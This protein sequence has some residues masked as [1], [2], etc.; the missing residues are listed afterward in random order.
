MNI[1]VLNHHEV[2]AGLPMPE[3]IDVMS[4]ALQSL[5]KGQFHLPLRMIIRPPGSEGFMALM[6]S[7][8]SGAQAAYALKA[9][10]IF[11]GNPSLGKDSHQGPVLLYS[12]ETGELL[13]IANA[14]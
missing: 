11:P 13:A 12:A 5:A 2:I 3:C 10:C 9:L 1:L 4:E 14:S 6:P 7:Y 8:R